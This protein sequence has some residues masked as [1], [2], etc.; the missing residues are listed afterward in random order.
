MSNWAI[1]VPL[2]DCTYTFISSRLE[3]DASVADGTKRSYSST[4]AVVEV[5]GVPEL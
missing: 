1:G 3:G 5:T 4:D 2:S